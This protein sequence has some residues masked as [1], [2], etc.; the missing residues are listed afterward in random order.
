MTQAH[1]DL[2]SALRWYQRV[3]TTESMDTLY[4]K[5]E[6][7]RKTNADKVFESLKMDIIKMR[8]LPGA[9]LSEA[10]LAL[11][12]GVSR[13]PVREALI[14]L[15][16]LRLVQIRAQRATKVRK[17]SRI[18]LIH[19]RFARLS[20]EL[21]MVR[22]AAQL[23]A[24]EHDKAF[25]ENLRQQRECLK[26]LDLNLFN[27][28]DYE[29]HHLISQAARA[30]FAFQSIVEAKVALDR[31][32]VLSMK[33]KQTLKRIYHDHRDIYRALKARDESALVNAMRTHLGRIDETLSHVQQV[34]AEFFVD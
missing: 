1:G 18:E 32:C 3:L 26:T 14:R 22:Q 31:L 23:Y 21:E 17:I 11:Q 29:F 2:S 13:Q 25:A 10:D 20:I 33:N 7:E 12:F 15:D 8:L 6:T 5:D 34:H 9:K 16:N 30:E 4:Y 27:V 28:L 24:G 19:S